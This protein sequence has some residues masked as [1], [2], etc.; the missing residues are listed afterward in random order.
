MVFEIVPGRES[1][2]WPLPSQALQNDFARVRDCFYFYAKP[3]YSLN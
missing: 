3:L 1:N 2:H